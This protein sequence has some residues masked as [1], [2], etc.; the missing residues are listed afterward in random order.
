MLDY[1]RPENTTS[2]IVAVKNPITPSAHKKFHLSARL[3]DRMFIAI[4]SFFAVCHLISV[5]FN[6]GAPTKTA[7]MKAFSK[8]FNLNAEG[9]MPNLFSSLILL[10]ASALLYFN[11]RVVHRK[12]PQAAKRPWLVL[13]LIFLFLSCDEA[14][15]IH[16]Q[17]M[18]V[19]RS[20]LGTSLNGF[21]HWAWV[22]P[23]GLLLLGVV[24]YFWRFVMRLPTTTRKLFFLSGFIYV[25]GALGIE[26]IEGYAYILEMHVVNEVLVLLQEVAEMAGIALFIHT[27]LGYVR[28]H[29]KEITMK[30]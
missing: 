23:Y 7:Y 8:L 10:V 20:L 9:G 3:I 26:V 11:Y 6:Y 27:L 24:A 22:V 21:L 14:F 2:Y 1:R 4:I 17:L 15:S 28:L 25:G 13:S 29:A 18:P 5:Y 12:A 30:F 16:E 19:T